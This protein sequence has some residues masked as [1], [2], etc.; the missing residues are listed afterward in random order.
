MPNGKACVEYR[1]SRAAAET[2]GCTARLRRADG[3]WRF[4]ARSDSLE[5][6]PGLIRGSVVEQWLH[7]IK[8]GQSVFG[9]SNDYRLGATTA[10]GV[11]SAQAVGTAIHTQYAL[12][13]ITPW[14]V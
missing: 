2:H 1:R 4:H 13:C 3:S 8:S 5:T 10:V 7:E 12:T 14:C 9:T 6:S 11:G